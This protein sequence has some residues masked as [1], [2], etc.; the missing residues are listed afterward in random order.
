MTLPDPTRRAA[1]LAERILDEIA[2]ADHDWSLVARFARELARVAEAA[3]DPAAPP[4]DRDLPE[5]P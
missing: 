5:A 4:T 2:S 1:D 3:S